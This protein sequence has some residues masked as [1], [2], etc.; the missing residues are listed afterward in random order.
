MNP[1]GLIPLVLGT[2]L[3][4]LGIS[5]QYKQALAVVSGNPAPTGRPV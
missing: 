5:G 2:I 4:A 1:A 3:L